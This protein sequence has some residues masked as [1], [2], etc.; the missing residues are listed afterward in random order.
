MA[1]PSIVSYTAVVLPTTS[2]ARLF[3]R[4]RFGIMPAGKKWSVNEEVVLCN[5]IKTHGLAWDVIQ[6]IL[7]ERSYQQCRAKLRRLLRMQAKSVKW[8]EHLITGLIASVL[9]HD[10]NWDAVSKDLG[11]VYT[12]LQCELKFSVVFGRIPEV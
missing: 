11:S 1:G 3:C 4:L 8:P 7:P 5:A 12:P 10:T 9:K 2:Q 6:Q